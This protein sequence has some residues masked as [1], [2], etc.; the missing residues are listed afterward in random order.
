[1]ATKLNAEGRR[2][3]LTD[4]FLKWSKISLSLSLA[5]GLFLIVLGPRFV[6]WWIGPEFE[7]PSGM[8]L[9]ILTVSSLV[10]LPIRGVAQPLMMGLG[11]PKAV[12]LGIPCGRH[13]EPGAQHDHGASVG[14][15][16]SS[17]RH[18][19]PQCGVRCVRSEC[20]VS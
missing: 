10:F 20:C 5:A 19:D 9:Q 6:A 2:A 17:P 8:V 15:R 3:E 16:R 12:T 4:I 7:R 11:K 18:R 14:A 13:R 1:M